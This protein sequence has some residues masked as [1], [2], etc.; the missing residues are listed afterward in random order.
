MIQKKDLDSTC[1]N[2]YY[3]LGIVVNDSNKGWIVSLDYGTKFII[4]K[5]LF[6]MILP[7]SYSFD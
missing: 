3:C 1:Y 6:S 5:E 4:V 7:N 2:N